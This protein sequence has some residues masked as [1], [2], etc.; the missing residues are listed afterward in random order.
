[1]Q[2]ATNEQSTVDFKY[3]RQ[4][5]AFQDDILE[6]SVSEFISDFIIKNYAII[7]QISTYFGWEFSYLIGHE[8]ITL[9]VGLNVNK[10]TKNY[11][12]TKFKLQQPQTVALM[13]VQ[14]NLLV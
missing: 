11:I 4:L 14:N 13:Y 1:M 6:F 3:I 12:V 10:Q 2:Q 9:V 7:Q 5:T 8:F